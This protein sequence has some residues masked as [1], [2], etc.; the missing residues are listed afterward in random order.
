MTNT[1]IIGIALLPSILLGLYIWVKDPQKE[2]AVWLIGGF[3]LGGALCV[4]VALLETVIETFLFGLC[5][6]P[7][8]MI[9]MSANAFIVAAIPEEG[10][11]LLAL[12]LLLR[13]NPHFD[14]HFDGIVYALSIG[15]GFA[16]VENVLYLDGESNWITIAIVR[17]LL[18]VPGHYAFAVLMGFFYSLYCFVDHSKKNAVCILLVP[19]LAHGIY[20]SLAMTGQV[21]PY[22]GCVGFFVLIIFCI[23][24]HRMAKNRILLLIKKDKEKIE[25]DEKND[26][27]ILSV[28]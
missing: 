23:R 21:N 5:F 11:K 28:S 13:W 10:I 27:Q 19:V 6:T 1:I 14:E 4:P 15:L 12:W 25:N 17:S 3:L 18:A 16:A 24:I 9:E 20:D 26:S 7:S 8:N 22:V 2:P